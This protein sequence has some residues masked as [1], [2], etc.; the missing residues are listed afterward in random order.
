[1]MIT[2]TSIDGKKCKHSRYILKVESI[3]HLDGLGI[4]LRGESSRMTLGS[5]L[6]NWVNIVDIY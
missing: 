5:W 1:M 3:R 2:Y 6:N 4:Q